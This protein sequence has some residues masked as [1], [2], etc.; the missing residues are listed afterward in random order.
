MWRVDS[1]D[2]T[3]AGRDWGQEEKG[4]TEDEMAGWHHGLDGRESEWTPGVGDGQGG[5][6]CCNSWGRKESDMTEQLNWTEL[7][8]FLP[9]WDPTQLSL[10]HDAFPR[11]IRVCS[12]LIAPT[13]F[14]SWEEENQS[15][16]FCLLSFAEYLYE[17]KL[18]SQRWVG[19]S[20]PLTPNSPTSSSELSPFLEQ[21]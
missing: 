21:G 16:L 15:P 9:I 3:D 13:I 1:L 20:S 12:D 11:E 2:K 14:Y 10:F 4:T 5:L 6:V 7:I 19:T 18:W 8:H 17:K